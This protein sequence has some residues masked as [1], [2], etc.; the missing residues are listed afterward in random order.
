M[1]VGRVEGRKVRSWTKI[2]DQIPKSQ[3][4]REK[5]GGRGCGW[6]GEAAV[7]ERCG[8]AGGTSTERYDTGVTKRH[9]V[10]E[11]GTGARDRALLEVSR[12]LSSP[13]SPPL[14]LLSPFSRASRRRA[15]TFCRKISHS[16]LCLGSK[17]S[18]G[19]LSAE[20]QPESLFSPDTW[21]AVSRRSHDATSSYQPSAVNIPF[22]L[23]CTAEGRLHFS[24]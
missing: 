18:S 17:I 2:E 23:I 13:L 1:F 7:S 16:P 12:C 5:C 3:T 4:H 9:G 8:A 20:S 10:T 11:P 24:R 6:C 21:P 14:F 15:A 22:S 19:A